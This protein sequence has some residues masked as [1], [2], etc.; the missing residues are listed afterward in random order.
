MASIKV[1]SPKLKGAGAPRAGS[2]ACMETVWPGG[3]L[4]LAWQDQ[5]TVHSHHVLEL[6]QMTSGYEM[7]TE[8]G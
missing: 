3:H 5:G 2:E 6:D 1:G 4:S 7:M 8:R